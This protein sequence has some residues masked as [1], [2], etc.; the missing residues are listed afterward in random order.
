MPYYTNRR[1]LEIAYGEDEVDG[2]IP[3]DVA[4]TKAAKAAQEEIDSYLHTAGYLLPLTFTEWSG[5]TPS[6][7][8]GLLQ[9]HSDAL[10]ASNLASAEDLH[11]QRYDLD[12]AEAIKWLE[13]VR[14]GRIRI[15]NNDGTLLTYRATV[16]G[17]TLPNGASL[18]ITV[19]RPRVFTQ[20]VCPL[21][22]PNDK[23]QL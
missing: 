13:Q 4:L 15:A 16:P 2:L 19:A 17:G 11:K 3:E 1:S 18:A 7:L 20:N 12:R 23:V 9:K 5:N 21:P 22:Y 8:P 10:A 6:T 14:D